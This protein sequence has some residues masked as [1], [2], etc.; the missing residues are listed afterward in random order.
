LYFQ[1]GL[2][3]RIILKI[4]IFGAAFFG[5]VIYGVARKAGA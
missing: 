2:K 4:G 5:G 3:T 1:A